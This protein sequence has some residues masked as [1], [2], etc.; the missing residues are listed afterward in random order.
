[1]SKAEMTIAQYDAR[2][3]TLMAAVTRARNKAKKAPSLAEKLEAKQAVRK[4]ED[5]LR[6]HRLDFCKLTGL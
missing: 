4:A 5:A 1:M 3:S 6:Q 2:H